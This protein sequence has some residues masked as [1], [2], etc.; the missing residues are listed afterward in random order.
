[1][2]SIKPSHADLKKT[3]LME[4]VWKSN[5]NFLKGVCLCVCVVCVNFIVTVILEKK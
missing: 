2:P 4:T 1:V 5:F 3:V